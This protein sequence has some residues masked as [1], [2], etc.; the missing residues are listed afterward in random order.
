M[1]AP[2]FSLDPKGVLID[3]LGENSERFQISNIYLKNGKG[4]T[5]IYEIK[6]LRAELLDFAKDPS[7]EKDVMRHLRPPQPKFDEGMTEEEQAVRMN[8]YHRL[9][10]E[11]EIA[12]TALK[13][14]VPIP[15]MFAIEQYME[16]FSETLHATPAVKGRRF[17]AFTKNVEEQQGGGLFGMGKAKNAVG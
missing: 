1:S 10:K 7:I 13:M 15:D 9:L 5:A 16:P 17:H 8:D 2:S 12:Q 6:R 3:K 11:W 14:Q 4:L